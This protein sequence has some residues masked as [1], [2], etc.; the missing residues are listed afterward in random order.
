MQQMKE[1][2]TPLNVAIVTGMTAVIVRESLLGT[3]GDIA[4]IVGGLVALIGLTYAAIRWVRGEDIAYGIHTQQARIFVDLL[5]GAS[6]P[7]VGTRVGI[8]MKNGCKVP[9]SVLVTRFDMKIGKELNPLTSAPDRQVVAPGASNSWH[10][11]QFDV[12]LVNLPVNVEVEYDIE[13]GRHNGRLR[14]RLNGVFLF[15]LVISSPGTTIPIFAS[16]LRPERD[17]RISFWERTG[18]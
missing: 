6:T 1:K 17:K 4:A 8:D 16:R 11:S 5:K 3:W 18:E 15:Q 10:R 12:P 13:Y 7:T 2:V 9:L 14:R